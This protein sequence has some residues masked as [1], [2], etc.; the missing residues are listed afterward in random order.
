MV[1]KSEILKLVIMWFGYQVSLNLFSERNSLMNDLYKY[2]PNL[3]LL[4]FLFFVLC[5]TTLVDGLLVL[6]RCMW[7]TAIVNIFFDKADFKN[8]IEDASP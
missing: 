5:H 4:C 6:F 8:K 7:H 3:T 2:Y 1:L